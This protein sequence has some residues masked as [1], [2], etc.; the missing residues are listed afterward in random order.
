V[1]PT[2]AFGAVMAGVI[3]L[4]SLVLAMNRPAP[5]IES[6]V[7][8]LLNEPRHP[9]TLKMTQ[10]AQAVVGEPAPEIALKDQD[11]KDFKLSGVVHD[12]P[13]LVV[14]VK[15]GCPCSMEAQ[16]FFNQLAKAYGSKAQFVGVT[17]AA[18]YN[19]SKFHDDFN[20]PYTL[21]SEPGMHTFEAYQSP[22][23]VY[24]TLIAKGGAVRHMWP[25]YSKQLLDEINS[26]LAKESDLPK[27][28]LDQKEAPERPSSGCK[29]GEPAGS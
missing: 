14:M 10:D 13:V 20:V 17:D 24:T 9:V 26:A 4:G 23:S 19:A 7:P 22:R 11:G 3:I 15:D 5:V 29:F 8:N 28:T 18:K 12:S 25:G 1:K 2:V 27:A 6:N 21:V 16:P